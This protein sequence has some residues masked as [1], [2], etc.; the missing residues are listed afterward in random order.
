MTHKKPF[1]IWFGICTVL[2]TLLLVGMAV[3]E[4]MARKRGGL[5]HHLHFRKV[6][7]MNRFFTAD[8]QQVFQWI[9]VA[10]TL[11]CLVCL[12]LFLHRGWR[13]QGVLW[14]LAGVASAFS[15]AILRGGMFAQMQAYPYLLAAIGLVLLLMVLNA[16][17]YSVLPKN[18]DKR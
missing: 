3:L 1:W 15:W 6:Q 11:I 5:N 16:V 13:A 4:R 14:G 12:V 7:F 10:V 17:L 18:I 2:Q 8:T 9:L